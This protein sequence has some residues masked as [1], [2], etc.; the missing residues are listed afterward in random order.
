MNTKFN[1]IIENISRAYTSKIATEATKAT[2]FLRSTINSQSLTAL[3][4]IIFAGE[5]AIYAVSCTS[6]DAKD[7]PTIA[8]TPEAQTFEA[9]TLS[10]YQ[11][12]KEDYPDHSGGFYFN[13]AN[14]IQTLDRDGKYYIVYDNLDA[15]FDM[16][17]LQVDKATFELINLAQS[18]LGKLTGYMELNLRE[19]ENNQ[20]EVYSYTYDPDE[21]ENA[22]QVKTSG[23]LSQLCTIEKNIAI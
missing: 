3:A 17:L 12:Y 19:T 15:E 8:Q 20:M 23:G 7:I 1:N 11:D 18:S 4:A 21:P 9:D 5:V 6:A 10:A 14:V 2:N 22:Q 13:S 16:E